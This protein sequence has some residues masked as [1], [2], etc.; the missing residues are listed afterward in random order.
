MGGSVNKDRRVVS[1]KEVTVIAKDPNDMA[2]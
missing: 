2:V 1:T